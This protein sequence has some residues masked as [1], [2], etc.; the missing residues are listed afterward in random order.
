MLLH[1]RLDLLFLYGASRPGTLTCWRRGTSTPQI[2]Q[3]ALLTYYY[4]D[5]INR[6][7]WLLQHLLFTVVSSLMNTNIVHAC[8]PS[9]YPAPYK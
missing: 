5:G 1:F 9:L 4:N 2:P 7:D 6:S 8:T 3:Q